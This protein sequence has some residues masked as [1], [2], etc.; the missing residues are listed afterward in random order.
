MTRLPTNS[1][2]VGSSVAD[3]GEEL[4]GGFFSSL[5]RLVSRVPPAWLS[6][7]SLNTKPQKLNGVRPERPAALRTENF[8][9]GL[10]SSTAGF[11]E[12]KWNLFMRS[13]MP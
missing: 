10:S 6:S 7:E 13:V 5:N 4:Q 1:F 12:W 3:A 2:V 8:F 9:V 11:E